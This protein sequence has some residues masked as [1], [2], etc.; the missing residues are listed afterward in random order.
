MHAQANMLLTLKRQ[1]RHNGPSMPA[2]RN[3]KRRLDELIT[4]MDNSLSPIKGPSTNMSP[5]S[6]ATSKAPRRA[7][8]ATDSF[9]FPNGHSKFKTVSTAKNER[10]QR[11]AGSYV[12]SGGQTVLTV[13]GKTQGVFDKPAYLN[14]ASKDD[15]PYVVVHEKLSPKIQLGPKRTNFDLRHSLH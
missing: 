13:D 10:R 7:G 14:S 11:Y 4:R 12:P 9:A 8:G 5:L 6:G 1:Y 15:L 3:T 2:T